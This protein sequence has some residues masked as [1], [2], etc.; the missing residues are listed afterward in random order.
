MAAIELIHKQ[1]VRW[2]D[3]KVVSCDGGGGPLGHPRVFINT[4]KPA[5]LPCGY[6]GVPFVCLPQIQDI[7]QLLTTY[8]Q[9]R[10]TAS[11]SRAFP[12]HPTLSTLPATLLRFLRLTSTPLTQRLAPLSL[13]SPT[14]ADLL[15][16]DRFD[17]NVL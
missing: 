9:T 15:S 3:Q 17:H 11:T 1:P 2:T 12:P 5:I 10:T 13:F 4:D 14:L 7:D 8:R 16:R 6:C